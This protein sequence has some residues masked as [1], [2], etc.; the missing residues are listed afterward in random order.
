MLCLSGFE[1]YSRWV[2]LTWPLFHCFETPIW[3]PWRHV[4]TLFSSSI[5]HQRGSG[6][7]NTFS[8]IPPFAQLKPV[9]NHRPSSKGHLYSFPGAHQGLLSSSKVRG[10]ESLSL[11]FLPAGWQISGGIFRHGLSALFSTGPCGSSSS[12]VEKRGMVLSNNHAYALF[13]LC[14]PLSLL[15]FIEIE[16]LQVILLIW[17]LKS[18]KCWSEFTYTP[19]GQASNWSMFIT[20]NMFIYPLFVVGAIWF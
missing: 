19:L 9:L 10:F 1:L 5:L 3:P 13:C 18:I 8:L 2:P 7:L 16:V 6:T 4:K 12:L 17:C 15:S 20:C 14:F 11:P